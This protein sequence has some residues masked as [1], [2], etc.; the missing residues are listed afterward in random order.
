MGE[1]WLEV[2]DLARDREYLERLQ[3]ATLEA[4]EFALASDHGLPGSGQW[5]TAIRDGSI[6]THGVEGTIT[7]VRV[8]GNWPEFEVDENGELTTWCLEG[9]IRS[10]RVGVGARIDYVIQRC[11]NPPKTSGDDSVKIVLRIFLEP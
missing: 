8:A 10:Y 3:L 5:W 6:P 9:D 2:Y 4:A 11:Q 7:D 1:E